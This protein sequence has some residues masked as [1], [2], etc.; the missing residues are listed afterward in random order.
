MDPQ[1]AQCPSTFDHITCAR[2]ILADEHCMWGLEPDWNNIWF[3]L[4]RNDF[5]VGHY[6]YFPDSHVGHIWLYGPERESLP[7]SA[8]VPPLDRVCRQ[9]GFSDGGPVFDCQPVDRS[10]DPVV[11][12]GVV[13]LYSEEPRCWRLLVEQ[14]DDAHLRQ[15]LEL[16][17]DKWLTERTFE[18]G[19]ERRPDSCPQNGK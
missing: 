12:N 2:L 19:F 11:A 9:I 1:Q 18:M 4:R 15:A 3:Q 16:F 7:E 14:V 17:A 10:G 8:T 6:H 13:I 5:V